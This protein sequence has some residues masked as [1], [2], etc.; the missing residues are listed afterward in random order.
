ML[1]ARGAAKQP[2]AKLTP[3]PSAAYFAGVVR[4]SAMALS[5]RRYSAAMSLFSSSAEF[6][7]ATKSSSNS[8]RM[9]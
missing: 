3:Q 4:R 2:M 1:P 6:A 5:G 9:T 7:R 8:A